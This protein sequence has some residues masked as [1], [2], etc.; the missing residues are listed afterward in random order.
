MG[1]HGSCG[2]QIYGEDAYALFWVED[3]SIISNSICDLKK[4]NKTLIILNYLYE[5]LF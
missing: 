1:V 4:G 3:L 2:C 5:L